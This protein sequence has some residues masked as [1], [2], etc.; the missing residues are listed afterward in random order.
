MQAHLC[1]K[2]LSMVKENLQY[3]DFQPLKSFFKNSG[4]HRDSNSQSGSPFGS[5]WT[6]SLTLFRTPK[7]V[8]VIPGLHFG[9][10]LF[11]PLALDTSPRLRSWQFNI[12]RCKFPHVKHDFF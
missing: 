5:M 4:L 8:N 1:L 3:N 11:T 9:S 2:S 10:H 7:S 6:H 12:D